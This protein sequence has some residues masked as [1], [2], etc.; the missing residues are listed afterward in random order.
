MPYGRYRRRRFN[1]RRR[2]RGR[3]VMPRLSSLQRA[4]YMAQMA[5]RGVRYIKGLVNSEKYANDVSITS[6]IPA[7]GTVVAL[8]DIAQGDTDITRTG[9]SIF[10]RS[11]FLRGSLTSSADDATGTV[12]RIILF[13]DTQQTSDTA[14]SAASVLS[15][16]DIDA[17][18]NRTTAGRYNIMWDMMFNM[19][20]Q[21][22]SGVNIRQVK[23]FQSL[24]HHVRYNGAASTDIQKNGI[25][26]LLLS[27]QATNTP[28][29]NLTARVMYHDN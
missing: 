11:V 22:D 21:S 28:T 5:W 17:P 10:V 29:P 4:L 13:S 15:G 3:R 8:T 24:R 20:L 7:T 1:R 2:G 19:P 9:N 6:A 12:V 23:R 14:P 25:Y 26:L 18:L 27:N 16:V